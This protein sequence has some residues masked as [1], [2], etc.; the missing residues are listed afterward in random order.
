MRRKIFLFVI[1]LFTEKLFAQAIP[2][3][4]EARVARLLEISFDQ[5]DEKL[6]GF[7][8][9]DINSYEWSE[10]GVDWL[11]SIIIYLK[12]NQT[13]GIRTV[14]WYTDSNLARRYK[15]SYLTALEN[16]GF[17]FLGPDREENLVYVL[18]NGQND[19]LKISVIVS[20]IIRAG[21]LV[22]IDVTYYPWVWANN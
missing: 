20:E 8:R 2:S 6:R 17:L 4:L 22:G 21:R 11:G 12:N 5:T 1:F 13:D 9:I 16:N 15:G 18:L 10:R 19:S 3:N 7:D 14:R